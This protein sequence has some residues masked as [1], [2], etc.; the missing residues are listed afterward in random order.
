MTHPLCLFGANRNT[1]VTSG[2][3]AI[4]PFSFLSDLSSVAQVRLYL[5]YLWFLHFFPTNCWAA[6]T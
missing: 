1:S 2:M 3:S 5:W 4:V 6:D